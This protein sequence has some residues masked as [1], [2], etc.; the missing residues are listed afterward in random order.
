MVIIKDPKLLTFEKVVLTGTIHGAAAEL[1]LSQ[2]AVTK[3]IQEL[4]NQ[5]RVSLFLRSRR[6]MNLTDEGKALLRYCQ[7]T[8]EAE[9]LLLAQISNQR[10]HEVSLSILGPTSAI[11]T[12]VAQNVAGLY[13]KYPYLRL[14][15]RSEDH[16]NIVE[17]VKKGESDFGIVSPA[18]VPKEMASKVLKSDRYLLVGSPQW[19][20]RP[21]SEIL[22]NERMI[23]FYENDFTTRNYLKKFDLESEVGKSRIFVNQNQALAR[24]IS[25]GVGYG[26]LTESIASPFIASGEL[27]KLNRGQ[28]ME[29]PLALIWYSRSREMEYF[30]SVIRAIK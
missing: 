26:T 7:S 3:R 21:L 6:G 4:E 2:V 29:D 24:M 28:V 16:I 18:L 12:R 19:K 22:K 13:Q 11:S 8:Q 27:I 9:G 15:L 30:D 23:D 20:S 5:L 25:T 10:R 14:H 1:G 17:A